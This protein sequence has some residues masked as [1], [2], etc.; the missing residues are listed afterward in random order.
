M[1]KKYATPFS[2]L[3]AASL[4][5]HKQRITKFAMAIEKHV[6]PEDYVID[7]GCG[8]GILSILAAKQGAKV[9]A[10][11]ISEESLRYAEKAARYNGVANKI[12]FV[13][14]N[15]MEYK[16]D[17]LADV[18][19]CE[20]LSSMMLIEQQIPASSYAVENLLKFGGKIIPESV[21]VFVVPV[22][23]EILWD[24]FEIQGLS[25]PRVPQTTEKEQ[26]RDLS[27]LAEI[28]SF[29]LTIPNKNP[30]VDKKISFKILEDGIVH[31]LVGMFEARLCEDIVLNMIDGW[32]ELFI[33][34][35]E[36]VRVAR[37]DVLETRL[38]YRPG[39]FDS[40]KLILL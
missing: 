21:Q 13:S 17:E 11:E 8:T 3:H 19:L 40:L 29:D 22:Q 34:L 4:L 20:M 38:L 31:G 23:N 32:R 35:N 27:D 15:I 30:V 25:F 14:S 10:I 37:G 12:K 16:P 1:T 18:I 9:T 33:P 2:L 28:A 36:P 26:Y 6:K 7:I 5:S 39:E 24:R